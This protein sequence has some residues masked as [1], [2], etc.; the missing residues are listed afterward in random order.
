M[1]NEAIR[2]GIEKNIT[3]K[4]T[5]RNELYLQFKNEF[6]TSYISMTVFQAFFGTITTPVYL[7]AI[8]FEII[9]KNTN[10]NLLFWFFG[11]LSL[12]ELFFEH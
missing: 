8:S 12:A 2:V 10:Q 11:F 6:H 1:I 3:S 7:S 9:H 4:L 5:L